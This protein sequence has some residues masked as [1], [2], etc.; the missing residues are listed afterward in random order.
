[1]L[2]GRRGKRGNR[3]YP[4]IPDRLP[5]YED[6]DSRNFGRNNRQD[7]PRDNQYYKNDNKRDFRQRNYNSNDNSNGRFKNNNDRNYRNDQEGPKTDNRVIKPI[8][9][10]DN[11]QY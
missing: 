5:D 11:S 6:E 7:F 3:V 2:C 9:P 8:P 10:T 4:I 1:M